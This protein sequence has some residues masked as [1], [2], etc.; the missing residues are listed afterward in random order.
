MFRRIVSVTNRKFL[1]VNRFIPIHS[2]SVT[3]ASRSEN[4]KRCLKHQHR[5]NQRRRSNEGSDTSKRWEPLGRFLALVS[6]VCFFFF[7]IIKWILRCTPGYVCV[8]W[9][10]IDI[11]QGR[12]RVTDCKNTMTNSRTY[13]VYFLWFIQWRIDFRLLLVKTFISMRMKVRDSVIWL[14]LTS[15]IFDD[16]T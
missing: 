10:R 9:Q 11:A 13:T 4:W 6:F 16:P 5:Q 8:R 2:R 7:F 15:Y 1:F 14:F 3:L 12:V